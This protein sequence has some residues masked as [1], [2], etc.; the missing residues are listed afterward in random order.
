[1]ETLFSAKVP[2]FFSASGLKQH[3]RNELPVLHRA[4]YNIISLLYN[5]YSVWE[6]IIQ[7][8]T[9]IIQLYK[10]Y[11]SMCWVLGSM[12]KT[13]HIDIQYKAGVQDKSATGLW[14]MMQDLGVQYKI[15]HPLWSRRASFEP[16]CVVSGSV[17]FTWQGIMLHIVVQ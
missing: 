17:H 1:M 14:R 6:T 10:Y 12:C 9:T 4:R 13:Q 7:Y 16:N 2:H 11:S 3:W 15:V 8:Y 5:Y